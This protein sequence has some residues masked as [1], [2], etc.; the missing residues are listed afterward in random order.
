MFYFVTVS[1]EKIILE[2]VR[3]EDRYPALDF[4]ERRRKQ[5]YTVTVKLISFLEPD[6][7][8]GE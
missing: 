2:K 3:F 8:K 6:K 1:D 5:G 7:Y 4:A